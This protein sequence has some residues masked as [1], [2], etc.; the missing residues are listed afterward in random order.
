MTASSSAVRSSATPAAVA[1]NRRG[2]D[3]LR[4]WLRTSLSGY[5]IPKQIVVVEAVRRAPNGKAD[6]GWAGDMAATAAAP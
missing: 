4:A 3:D 1:G 5:E 2:G 6:Y